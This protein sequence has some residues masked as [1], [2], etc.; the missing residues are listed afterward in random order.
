M[1][2]LNKKLLSYWLETM[3][4]HLLID[5]KTW[6]HTAPRCSLCSI[7][8]VRNKSSLEL[9]RSDLNS[10]LS[11]SRETYNALLESQ[12]VHGVSSSTEGISSNTSPPKSTSPN[13]FN[14]SEFEKFLCLQCLIRKEL[15]EKIT[16]SLPRSFRKSLTLK[17]PLV[18]MEKIPPLPVAPIALEQDSLQQTPMQPLPLEHIVG[19]SDPLEAIVNPSNRMSPPRS[20][21]LPQS[22]G[23]L[24]FTSPLGTSTSPGSPTNPS[25]TVMTLDQLSTYMAPVESTFQSPIASMKLKQLDMMEALTTNTANGPQKI[26]F[27]EDDVSLPSISGLSLTSSQDA[28]SASIPSTITMVDPLKKPREMTLLPYLISKG[29]F[30]EA[31]RVVRIALGKQAVD[32]G[33]GMYLLLKILGLQADMYKMMGLW[34][35]AM[36]IYVDVAE[37]TASLLGLSDNVT[38]KAL[39]LVSSCFRKMQQPKLAEDFM[40]HCIE[41]LGQNLKKSAKENMIERLQKLNR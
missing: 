1:D 25:T 39:T 26:V 27:D 18:A 4:I 14:S 17:W 20:P 11:K 3:D 5:V 40:K 31:E 37:L 29:H 15:F 23:M 24:S 2:H 16:Q 7:G 13:K 12:H 28:S 35:L 34:A 38:F 22:A 8:F 36:A 6:E 33:E 21:L 32:E 9:Y 19:T 30:E 10:Y 41:Q